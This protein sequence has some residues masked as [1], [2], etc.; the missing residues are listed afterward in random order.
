MKKGY[1]DVIDVVGKK[2]FDKSHL[3]KKTT[4]LNFAHFN[5]H[6]QDLYF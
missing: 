1:M 5:S 6:V 3:E 2:R 4:D